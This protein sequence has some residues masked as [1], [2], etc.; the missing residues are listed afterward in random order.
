MSHAH[1]YT[2]QEN[3]GYR[4]LYTTLPKK[5]KINRKYFI[6]IVTQEWPKW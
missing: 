5:D 4:N 2:C 6:L 1:K 3:D